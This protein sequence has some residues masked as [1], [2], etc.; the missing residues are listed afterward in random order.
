MR[1]KQARGRFAVLAVAAVIVTGCGGGRSGDDGSAAAPPSETAA[2]GQGDTFGSLPSP[3]GPAEVAD[4]DPGQLGVTTDSITIGYGDDAGSQVAPGLNRAMGDAMRAMIDWCNERG[5]INGRKVIGNYYD[6]RLFDSA[7]V[8]QE[9]CEQAFALVGQGWAFD[10]AAEPVRLGCGLPSVPGFTGTALAGMGPLTVAPTPNPIDYNN[11]SFA[12]ALAEAFPDKVAKAAVMGNN[13]ASSVEI[14]NKV[15]ATYPDAGFTFLD[16]PQ[17]YSVSGE[18]TWAPFVQRLKECG[19]E[20]VF[21]G[22]TETTLENVLDAASIADY[23]P[24]W[25]TLGASYTETFAAWN[26]S[27]NADGVYV[28]TGFVPFELAKPG[29]ATQ[30]YLD[31]VGASGGSISQLGATSASAFLLW[32]TAAKECGA[33]LTRE[34]LMRNL[35]AV[36]HWDGGGLHVPTDPGANLPSK[37]GNALRLDGTAWTQWWPEGDEPWACSDEYLV[38][39]DPPIPGAAALNLGP[40][41][42]VPTP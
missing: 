17:Q 39:I 42:K 5:G 34:C 32:A 38:R 21:F 16:C 33:D 26:Q 41:R 37:C 36:H 14:T 4:T 40:D 27:G 9:A 15:L 25:F 31:I 12:Y 35:S 18:A 22:G 10:D 19:A 29:S 3:C 11:V 2:A 6:A 28:S 24:V 8:A 13:I 7:L 1:T 20:A 23:H 30:A